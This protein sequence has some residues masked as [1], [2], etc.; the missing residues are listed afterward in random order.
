MTDQHPAEGGKPDRA[1]ALMGRPAGGAASDA[2]GAR[3]EAHQRTGSWMQTFT[4]RQFW[5]LDPRP[6]EIVIEDIAHALSMQCRY[7]GHCVKFYSVAEHCVLLA[8]HVAPPFKLWALL[9]DASEAY[10][11]DIIRPIKNDIANYRALEARL[12]LAVCERF[13]LHPTMPAAVAEADDRIIGDERANLS[14]CKVEWTDPPKPLG[15]RLRN[16]SPDE[17]ERKFLNAFRELDRFRS[18]FHAARGHGGAGAMKAIHVQTAAELH[19]QRE[20]DSAARKRLAGGEKLT[21][22]LGEGRPVEVVLTPGFAALIRRQMDAELAEKIDF[23]D[24]KL[25]ELGVEF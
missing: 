17:A 8:D 4:G 23:L 5:P 10:L 15:V 3:R 6:E 12:M 11:A 18:A 22:L 19:R 1:S 9:H 7:A 21:L 14:L 25:A 24:R 2:S 16:W 20:A 13:G